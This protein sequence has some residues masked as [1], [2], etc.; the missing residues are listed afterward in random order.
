MLLMLTL[1]MQIEDLQ[2]CLLPKIQE[3]FVVF[4][5]GRTFKI[6]KQNID[7]YSVKLSYFQAILACILLIMLEY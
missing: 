2:Q 7:N 5:I 1:N 4:T 3:I 6:Y